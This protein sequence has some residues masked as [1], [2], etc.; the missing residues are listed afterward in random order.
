MALEQIVLVKLKRS[1]FAGPI[2]LD[3]R[4]SLNENDGAIYSLFETAKQQLN[5]SAQK[6][7]GFFDEAAEHKQFIGLLNSLENNSIDFLSFANKSAEQLQ[8]QMETADT[9][10]TAAFIFAQESLLGQNYLYLLWLPTTDIIQTGPD[11]APYNSEQIDAAKLPFALRIHLDGLKEKSSPKYLTQIT[12]RGSKDLTDAFNRFSNFTEGVDLKQQTTEFL[13]IVDKFSE[14]L[15]EEK[16]KQV[17]TQI[18]DYCVEKDKIGE[19]VLLEDI[20]TQLDQHEPKKF[21]SFVTGEQKTPELEILTDRSSLKKYMRY[22][23]RDNTL[24]I[25]FSAERYGEDIT[26]DPTTGSLN[27]HQLPKSLKVQLSGFANKIDD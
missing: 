20:S 9:P 18:I 25:S 12:S 27:I 22:S 6:R 17:K 10:F 21:T 8:V 1:E 7:F 11:L 13:S 4:S 2:T 24:S 5:R 19:P 26:Y 15:P 3:K 23:G 16:S 14:D